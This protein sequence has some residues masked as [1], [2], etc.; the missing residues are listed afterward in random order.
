MQVSIRFYSHL[1]TLIGAQQVVLDLPE[2]ARLN[3]LT[4]Q[5][6]KSY[7]QHTALIEQ[8]VFLAD[9]RSITEQTELTDGAKLVAVMIL[10]G[11]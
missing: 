10:S 7:P 8:L 11:G 2:A 3:D 9:G 6:V 1:S 4:Q 5:L